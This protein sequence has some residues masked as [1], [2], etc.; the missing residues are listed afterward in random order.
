MGSKSI[1]YLYL[2]QRHRLWRFLD[3][4]VKCLTNDYGLHN[5]TK[6]DLIWCIKVKLHHCFVCKSHLINLPNGTTIIEHA[7]SGKSLHALIDKRTILFFRWRPWWRTEPDFA[8][9]WSQAQFYRMHHIFVF[10]QKDDK[11]FLDTE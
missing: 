5:M 10:K 9:T 7:V 4:R 3:Q 1:I 2:M 6:L 8:T 11:T